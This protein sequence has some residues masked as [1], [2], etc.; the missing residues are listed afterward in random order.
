MW[1]SVPSKQISVY[2]LFLPYLTADQQQLCL[3]CAVLGFLHVDQY[4]HPLGSHCSLL[5]DSVV[6]R[7][8]DPPYG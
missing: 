7:P 8:Y 2:G 1:F 4:L 3:G 6:C 5:G